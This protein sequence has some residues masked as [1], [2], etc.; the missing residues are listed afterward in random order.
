MCYEDTFLAYN[1]PTSVFSDTSFYY[2]RRLG[3]R[4]MDDTM[5]DKSSVSFHQSSS[6]ACMHQT[7]RAW[8]KFLS[9]IILISWGMDGHHLFFFS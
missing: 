8:G 6:S 5:K 3:N 9:D 1:F 2:S 4:V 7:R